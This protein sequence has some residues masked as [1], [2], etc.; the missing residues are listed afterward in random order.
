MRC[1]VIIALLL[2][3]V[4]AINAFPA[5]KTTSCTIVKNDYGGNCSGDPLPP[6]PNDDKK[7]MMKRYF[8]ENLN[9]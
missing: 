6:G 9:E 2:A 3:I 1:A 8:N 5:Y 4:V 7:R